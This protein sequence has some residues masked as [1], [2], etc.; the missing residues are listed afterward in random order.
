MQNQ[1]N[2]L[3][4]F[5]QKIEQIEKTKNDYL[6][7][8]D[9]IRMAEDSKIILND[10]LDLGITDYAHGQIANKLQIPK[11]YYDRM[12]AKP[13]LRTL[14][15]NTWLHD[16]EEKSMVRTLDGR[17]RAM[18]SDQFKPIDN[19]DVLS[20][21]IFPALEPIK[22]NIQIK[23]LN[24]SETK[25]YLQFI[26]KSLQAEIKVNDVVQYGLTISNSEVGAG[27]LNVEGWIYRLVCSNGMVR[28]SLFKKYHV[29]RRLEE[30]ENYS[31]WASDT[32]KKELEGYQLRLRDVLK[33]ALTMTSFNAEVRKMK[34]A[35][36]DQIENI[37]PTI[38][39]V[40]KRFG[41][42]EKEG[43][44]IIQQM[45][46]NGD[47][48]RWGLANGL[49]ALAHGIENPD[50]QYHC[51]KIGSEIIDLAPSEWKLLAA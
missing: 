45:V 30:D 48:T 42:T 20:T 34:D 9:K 17:V 36:L 10:E 11:A 16:R 25:M 38:Q 43:D 49:T 27:S 31:I 12:L 2:S 28:N 5:A 26:V 4:D 15:V 3:T 21:S 19:Y 35:A 51:E 46:S 29:G 41:L 44:H 32:L 22:N 40:T 14:N 39:N 47:S 13:G 1:F 23:A 7:S 18:L 37:T 33:N 50:R 8:G 6:V 24:L